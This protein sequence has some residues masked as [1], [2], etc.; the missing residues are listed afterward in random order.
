VNERERREQKGS[1]LQCTDG[2]YGAYETHVESNWRLPFVALTL[3]T[4]PGV[5]ARFRRYRRYRRSR[6]FPA[7][8]ALSLVALAAR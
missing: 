8:P 4:A 2:T 5:L 6:S 1:A 3:S 7:F